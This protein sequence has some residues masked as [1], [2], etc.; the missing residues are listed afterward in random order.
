MARQNR[1]P[2]TTLPYRLAKLS[3]ALGGVRGSVAL[4]GRAQAD[5]MTCRVPAA[6][7]DPSLAGRRAGGHSRDNTCVAISCE[8]RDGGPSVFAVLGRGKPS[9]SRARAAHCPHL[10][11]GRTLVHDRENSHNAVARE[12]HLASEAYDSR[13][14]K[15]LPDGEDPLARVNRP[16]FPLRLF[17]D[18]HTGFGRANLPGWLDPFSVMTNPP[19]SKMGKAAMA[20]D[21][22]TAFPNTLR[23][24]DFYRGNPSSGD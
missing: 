10:A 1:R 18:G 21:R 17:L 16:C 15:S 3:M 5:E 23:Y 2:P 6:G 13:L 4:S 19:A 8:E 20:L 24:R 22:A 7:G 9:A 11:D 14:V 12:R